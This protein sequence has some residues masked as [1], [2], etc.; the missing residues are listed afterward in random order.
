MELDATC[1]DSHADILENCGIAWPNQGLYFQAAQQFHNVASSRTQAADP[2]THAHSPRR[3]NASRVG[4]RAKL[5]P[6]LGQLPAQ[7]H[8]SRHPGLQNDDPF[9]PAH[10]LT[11]DP[12]TGG[13]SLYNYS[14]PWSRS[15]TTSGDISMK[16]PSRSTSDSY[17]EPMPDVTRPASPSSSRR[18]YPM[19]DCSRPQSLASSRQ[20]SWY[21]G[22][23]S[24]AVKCSHLQYVEE[25]PEIEE[26]VSE[27]HFDD[28]I[29]RMSPR[30]FSANSGISAPSN[31]R[32]SSAVNTPPGRTSPAAEL[33]TVSFAGMPRSVS[34]T[35]RDPPPSFNARGPSNTGAMSELDNPRPASRHS[36]IH[37]EPDEETEDKV[38]KRPV[39]RPAGNV[40]SRKE[41]RSSDIGLEV[42]NSKSQRRASAPSASALGKENSG[43]T[44]A[45]KSGEGKRKRLT[46]VSGSKVNLKK[47]P[48][49]PDSSPTRKVSKLSAEDTMQS[50]AMQSNAMQSNDEVEY[51]IFL[52]VFLVLNQILSQKTCHMRS[53]QESSRCSTPAIGVLTTVL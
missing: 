45:E 7:L 5:N 8:G 42:P 26:Q 32:V 3:R 43:A 21:T 28:L 2:D 4:A 47:S 41:G 44:S 15:T 30:D 9:D 46:K 20:V 38:K 29:A 12:F 27:N 52:P 35:S 39:G 14:N 11:S 22:E 6:T 34:I 33:R 19:P 16:D 13:V 25:N 53:S 18:S 24:A 48:N 37:E 51:V 49:N 17:D 1:A 40:K 50:N 31:T 23:D 36:Q 10:G